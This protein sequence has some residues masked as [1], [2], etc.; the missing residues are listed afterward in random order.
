MNRSTR[1]APRRLRRFVVGAVLVAFVGASLTTLAIATDTFGAGERWI[2]LVARLERLM[3]GPVPDRATLE[4]VLVD[5]APR[6]RSVAGAHAGR[7]AARTG[8]QCTAVG[9]ARRDADPAP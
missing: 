4:T 6:G 9:R 1:R 3:A 8:R 2:S 5:R 7:L